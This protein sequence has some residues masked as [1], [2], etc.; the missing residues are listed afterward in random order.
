MKTRCKEKMEMEKQVFKSIKVDMDR[1]QKLLK[2]SK[3]DGLFMSWHMNL[4]IDI[5]VALY[6]VVRFF[7]KR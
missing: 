1:Y 6:G 5:Y 2:V 7:P 4:A 3:G